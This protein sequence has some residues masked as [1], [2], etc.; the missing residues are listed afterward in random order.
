MTA[1]GKS[2]QEW[3][4]ADRTQ[5]WPPQP[6]SIFSVPYGCSIRTGLPALQAR[7]QPRNPDGRALC[8]KRKLCTN[9]ATV[10]A[11]WTEFQGRRQRA[12]NVI[13]VLSQTSKPLTLHAY[14]LNHVMRLHIWSLCW[15]LEGDLAHFIFV[16]R[17]TRALVKDR[18]IR[19]SHAVI[20]DHPPRVP[21]TLSALRWQRVAL[22]R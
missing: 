2:G 10:L 4:L 7:R 3:P 16:C 6:P 9:E 12:R 13:R 19:P 11:I 18:N 17:L 14:L 21:T 22:G 5:M 1:R 15:C 20:L 8:G